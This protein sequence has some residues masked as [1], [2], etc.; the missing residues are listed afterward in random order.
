MGREMKIGLAEVTIAVLT[1]VLSVGG[2]WVAVKETQAA[3]IEKTSQLEDAM[4]ANIRIIA[5]VE[6]RLATADTERA[7]LKEK[8]MQLER[9]TR[10]YTDSL[11]GLQQVLGELNVTLG[12]M[13]ERLKGVEEG[14]K[15]IRE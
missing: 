9:T 12:R 8:D 2:S 4:S 15:D 11:N 7:V 6:K 3:Q 14:I 5:E 1:F 13:D 10:T